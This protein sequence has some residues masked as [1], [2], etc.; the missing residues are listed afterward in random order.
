MADLTTP[1]TT[2]TEGIQVELTPNG[3]WIERAS[4]ATAGWDTYFI[5][6]AEL[7]RQLDEHD[8]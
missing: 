2:S 6:A 8:R 3:L 7:H 5:P 1:D 4:P